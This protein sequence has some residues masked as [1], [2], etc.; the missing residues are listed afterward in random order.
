VKQSFLNYAG[1]KAGV[2]AVPGD[3]KMSSIA[4]QLVA[5]VATLLG[6]IAHDALTERSSTPAT[7]VASAADSSVDPIVTR[8]IDLDGISS[9]WLNASARAER[10]AQARPAMHQS[11]AAGAARAEVRQIQVE[12]ANVR[13]NDAH[14]A[15]DAQKPAKG[16]LR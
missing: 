13:V 6:F 15:T 5:V 4:N 1:N 2:T 10:N 14:F 9:E 3:M 16:F 8:A 12:F 7:L 11:A